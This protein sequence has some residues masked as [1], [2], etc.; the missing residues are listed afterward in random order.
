MFRKMT[1]VFVA[2]IM[3]L[4]L[5]VTSCEEEKDEGK[6]VEEGEGQVITT[7]TGMDDE[8]DTVMEEEDELLPPD[9][10]KYGGTFIYS[11]TLDV[12]GFDP[13]K[14][15]QME[16]SSLRFTNEELMRGDWAKGMAGTGET[17]WTAGFIGRVE[18][19]TGS[20]AESWETPD[21]ETIIFHIRPGIHY[22]LDPNSEASLYVNGR[23]YTADDAAYSID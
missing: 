14:K 8:E 22:G 6:V 18:L 12:M 20:L 10:P 13:I 1:W 3:V 23:E 11:Q 17:D 4:S 19:E 2:L 7:V 9:V 21:S 15:L 16:C 5:V